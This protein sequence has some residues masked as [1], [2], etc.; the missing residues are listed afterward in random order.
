MKST[1]SSC[2]CCEAGGEY[3]QESSVYLAVPR[4]AAEPRQGQT[5]PILG[6]LSLLLLQCSLSKCH[7]HRPAAQARTGGT[8]TSS[9]LS[10]PPQADTKPQCSPASPCLHLCHPLTS[11]Q[12]ILQPPLPPYQLILFPHLSQCNLWGALHPMDLLLKEQL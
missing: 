9:L 11:P 12:L 4:Q 5:P 2:C 6:A 1:N 10:P 3:P 8:P 7:R